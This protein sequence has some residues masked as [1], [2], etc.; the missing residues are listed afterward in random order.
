MN[1]F[2][3]RINYNYAEPG[4]DM[5]INIITPRFIYT[6]HFIG[7][8][9]KICITYIS[10]FLSLLNSGKLSIVFTRF[11]QLYWS[12]THTIVN[13]FVLLIHII[14]VTMTSNAKI[15]TSTILTIHQ[16][17]NVFDKSV[18][19]FSILMRNQQEVIIL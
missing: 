3:M 7:D 8:R 18:M 17:I 4:M 5:F 1:T 2:S 9:F 19:E 6:I 11:D 14:K 13:V 16:P 15:I 10:I 12:I